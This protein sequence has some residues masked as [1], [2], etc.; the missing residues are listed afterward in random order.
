MTPPPIQNNKRLKDF[1]DDN[2]ADFLY[3]SQKQIQ[4]IKD[5]YA[6]SLS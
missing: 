4:R 1:I 3:L 5:F 6:M 2:P